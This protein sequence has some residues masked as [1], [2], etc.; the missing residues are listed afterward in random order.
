MTR[1]KQPLLYTDDELKRFAPRVWEA[2]HRARRENEE[3][4]RAQAAAHKEQSE[5]A[6]RL[7][8][9]GYKALAMK[10]HPD[11]GGSQ[12][13]MAR[14]NLVRNRLRTSCG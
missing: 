7:I 4:R 13:A 5:L 3:R 1:R 12:D 10:L 9:I 2:M 11:K 6:L 8:D 14:L